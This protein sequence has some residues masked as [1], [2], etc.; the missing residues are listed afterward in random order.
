M[1]GSRGFFFFIGMMV[2]DRL[3]PVL[4]EGKAWKLM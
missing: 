1:L 3:I 4:S 2:K